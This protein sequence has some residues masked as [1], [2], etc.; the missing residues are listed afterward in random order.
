MSEPPDQTREMPAITGENPIL[1]SI[2]HEVR[3][4]LS[5]LA[6]HRRYH[7]HQDP[8]STYISPFPVVT[9]TPVTSAITTPERHHMA[10]IATLETDAE[11]LR[12]QVEEFVKS[13]LPA[14]TA[15]L[16]KLEGLA[17][18]PVVL[19]LLNA[20]H[21]PSEALTMAVKVIDGLED[22]YKPETPVAAP[23]AP[24]AGT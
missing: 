24:A 23:A 17:S 3:G 4:D 6:H 14:A 9:V 5:R 2:L 8:V 16:K 13:K 11:E 10:L 19:S 7:D 15:D 18:N 22:L 12:A 1:E 20:V 21:V